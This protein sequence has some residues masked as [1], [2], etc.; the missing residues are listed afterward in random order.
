MKSFALLAVLVLG[1]AACD[2]KPVPATTAPAPST[3]PA[4]AAPAA[5]PAA[6]AGESTF[7]FGGIEAKTNVGFR[8]KTDITDIIGQSRKLRGSATIDFQKGTG[9]CALSIPTA[10]LNSGMDDRDR[11]MLGK[12]WLDAKQFPTI[13]FKAENASAADPRTWKLSGKFTLHGVS[14]DLEVAADVRY[15]NEEISK[16]GQCRAGR[17]FR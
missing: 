14:K 9:H 7:H 4:M 5:G 11:A 8:S 15:F 12:Q 16:K 17:V 13:E 6:P 1:L 2:Q 3:A 10:T